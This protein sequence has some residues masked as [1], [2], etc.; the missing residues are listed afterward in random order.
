MKIL[1]DMRSSLPTQPLSVST[2]GISR[3]T[4]INSSDNSE[5]NTGP[6]LVKR[7][8]EGNTGQILSRSSVKLLSLAQERHANLT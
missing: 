3:A 5:H 2:F 6:K 4:D 7:I 8:V 1:T